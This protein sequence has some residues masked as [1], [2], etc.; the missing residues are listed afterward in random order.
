MGRVHTVSTAGIAASERIFFWNAG[1]HEIGG[2]QATPLADVFEAEASTR[3]LGN[4]MVFGLRAAPHRVQS[5]RSDAG[6]RVA[7]PFL[8][9]RYQRSGQSTI[10]QD[11]MR[12]VMRA[13]E[14]MVFD[15]SRPHCF[16]NE[17]E[18]SQLSLQLPRSVLSERDYRLAKSLQGPFSMDGRV[19]K[20]LF[21]CLRLS[22]EELDD[23]SEVTEQALGY[24]M[25][26][27]FRVAINEVGSVRDRATGREVMEQRV[28]E[29]IRRNLCDPELSVE[30]IAKAMGCSPRYIHKT[31]EGKESVSRL[32]WSQRLDRCRL[33]LMAAHGQSITLTELAYEFGFSS[34][35][36][37]SRTFR[38]RFGMTPSDFRI[39]V[40]D[41][42]LIN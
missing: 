5:G 42:S 18:A 11:G 40:A 1:S 20:L 26:E 19:S 9:L 23:T 7:D 15:S 29:Y 10:E 4:L 33:E 35:A 41:G 17:Q 22:I 36:H 28:R 13:G 24:S 8:R 2:V 39:R 16:V 27:M 21:E 14:W 32:I 25:L 6:I 12:R 37:F 3:R 34:S 31:F 30:S 38:S